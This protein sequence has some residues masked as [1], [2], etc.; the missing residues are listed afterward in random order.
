MNYNGAAALLLGLYF[1][2]VAWRGNG[3]TLATRARDDKGFVVWAVA[4]LGL[5]AVYD[6]TKQRVVLMLLVTAFVGF[7]ITA[8]SQLFSSLSGVMSKLKG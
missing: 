6:N 3:E 8:G 2:A 5:W 1:L 4:L 7:F